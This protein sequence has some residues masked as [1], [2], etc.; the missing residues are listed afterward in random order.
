ML[1]GYY[2]LVTLGTL[3]PFG[4]SEVRGC[5]LDFGL[6]SWDLTPLLVVLLWPCLCRLWPSCADTNC[7]LVWF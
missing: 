5:Y 4:T 7:V 2:Y 6:D 3:V 1:A